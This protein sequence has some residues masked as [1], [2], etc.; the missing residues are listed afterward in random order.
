M[1]IYVLWQI[2]TKTKLLETSF[3]RDST[4]YKKF[5]VGLHI[6][7]HKFENKEKK[8]LNGGMINLSF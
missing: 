5:F 2:I 7:Q 6:F 3:G 8:R 4:I 1:E